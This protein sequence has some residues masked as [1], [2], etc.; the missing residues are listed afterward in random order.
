[1]EF[2][3]AYFDA[4]S[5]IQVVASIKHRTFVAVNDAPPSANGTI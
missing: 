3:V 1:M 4:S 5:L 2:G